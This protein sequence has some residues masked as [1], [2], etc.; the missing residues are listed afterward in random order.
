[1]LG[2]TCKLQHMKKFVLSII[3]AAGGLLTQTASAQ[4]GV[5]VGVRIGPVVINVHK[6]VSPAVVYDDFYYLPEVEAYYSVPEQCYY[7]M[8]ANRRWV[9]APYLPGRYRNYDWRYAQRYEI[10]NQRPFD[11]HVY[12]RNRFGGNPGR[13]WNNNWNNN[14]YA[15]KGNDRRDNRDYGRRYPDSP[16]DSNNSGR[17]GYNQPDRRN[18]G[19][20]D[21]N[22]NNNNRRNDNNGSQ[23]RNRGG[24]GLD[25]NQRGNQD[26]DNVRGNER[27][28]NRG[29]NQ[30]EQRFVDNN[31]SDKRLDIASAKRLSY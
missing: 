19:R 25:R 16:Y 8:N 1:M 20:G 11:N 6:P 22:W 28:N 5:S 12:Y 24:Y 14:R 13:N 21:N 31:G 10:R 15:D 30:R 17:G 3:I 27:D 7:Y 9:N 26:R 29:S 2:H 23:D 18:D 4:V